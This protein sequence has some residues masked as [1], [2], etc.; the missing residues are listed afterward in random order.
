MKLLA[1]AAALTALLALPS[2]A[3]AQQPWQM[4][5]V[6]STTVGVDSSIIT[7][8]DSTKMNGCIHG[9]SFAQFRKT[10]AARAL[11]SIITAGIMRLTGATI[12]GQ[13]IWGTLSQHLLAD[14]ATF[15][16]SATGSVRSPAG[17]L[18]GATLKSTV[19][20]SSLTSFG[21]GARTDSA[22]GAARSQT[23]TTSR[24]LWGVAFNGSA[25]VT[26]A[27][28]FG[29]GATN[30]GLFVTDS[31]Q[32]NGVVRGGAG[33]FSSTL[34]VQSNA[35]NALT[36]G[37]GGTGA[38]DVRLNVNGGSGPG[39]GAMSTYARNGVARL[40]V[41]TESSINGGTVDDGTVYAQS[42]LR[43]YGGGVQNTQQLTLNTGTAVFGSVALSGITT[44]AT[45]GTTT[46]TDNT[47]SGAGD[48]FVCKSAANVL[49]FGGTACLAS[50][51]KIKQNI[52][53]FGASVL[54]LQPSKWNYR[55]QFYGGRPDAGL[56]AEQVALVDPLFAYY[57]TKEDTLLT[58][59]VTRDSTKRLTKD[60]VQYLTKDATSL[61]VH[62]GDPVAVNWPAVTGALI[63]TVQRQQK[64][65]DSLRA[66]VQA[67]VAKYPPLSPMDSASIILLPSPHR[68]TLSLQSRKP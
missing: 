29:S 56:I 62:K 43:L 10:I 20:A 12:I 65:I 67:L 54:S 34:T 61:I 2:I 19:T 44:L 25:N 64:A 9:I 68:D 16:D 30:T 51:Q 5:R 6:T 15:A 32:S 60:S 37:T 14:S 31:I 8:C 35:T 24:N 26:A 40:Y 27:P 28:T 57:S 52:T 22:T 46:L 55:P 23:L 45:S 59:A 58:G 38:T 53:P 7:I 33:A 13:P 66:T 63:A 47:A 50:T 18:T 4:A 39:G 49:H 11:D 17:A 36:V 3:V 41:G 42:A 21:S 1:K 48:V